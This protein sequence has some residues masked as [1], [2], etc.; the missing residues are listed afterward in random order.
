VLNTLLTRLNPTTATRFRGRKAEEAFSLVELM[1][2]VVIIGI[3]AA[4][5]IPVFGS[6]QAASHEAALKSDLVNISKRL[7]Q[8]TAIESLTYPAQIPTGVR[9]SEGI[10]LEIVTTGGNLTEDE[11]G[12]RATDGWTYCLEGHA[13]FSPEDV[14]SFD[15][16]KG[17][18]QHK[19][20]LAPDPEETEE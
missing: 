19:A 6:Q 10:V 14:W 1:I 4:I 16:L 7:Q 5:A 15:L 20:C 13:N 9:I 12:W 17:K 18:L 8:E 11:K 3:L 2:V